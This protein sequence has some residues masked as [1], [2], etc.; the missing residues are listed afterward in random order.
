MLGEFRGHFGRHPLLPGVNQT[1]GLQKF[2]PQKTLEQ[3]AASAGFERAQHLN[4]SR[5]SG[6]NNNSRRRK[7]PANRNH[8]IDAVHFRHLQIHQGYIRT[9]DSELFDRLAA[10]GSLGNEC[11]VRLT[12]QEG[13]H[14]L[15]EERMVVDR[16]NAN[17]GPIS[18]HLGDVP[19]ATEP[20]ILNSTSVPAPTSLHISSCA[21][22]C[23]ARSRM[24]GN[25]QCPSRPALRSFGSMPLPLS[26]I[27]S[28]RR[29]SPYAIS[30]SILL[31]CAWRNA[32]RS[33]SR[34]MR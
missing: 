33:A 9:M 3:V 20:G 12:G 29:R 31:A 30:A 2:L 11:H 32:L 1:D 22:I 4:V 23:W 5:V 28:R 18:A 13:G 34:A 14:A 15:A 27:R 26:R 6:Q 10:V 17:R 16:E 21:P 25:P 7:L 24:P 19:Y 8:G